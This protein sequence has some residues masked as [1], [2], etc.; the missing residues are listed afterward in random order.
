[1]IGDMRDSKNTVVRFVQ[2]YQPILDFEVAV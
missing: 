2:E 1:M